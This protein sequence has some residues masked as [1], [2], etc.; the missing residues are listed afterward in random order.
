MKQCDMLCEKLYINF[1]K[2][3]G[4]DVE[5]LWLAVWKG[6]YQLCESTQG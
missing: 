4:G 5:A 6:I 1:V 3:R 2:V